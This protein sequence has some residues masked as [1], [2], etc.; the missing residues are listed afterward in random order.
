MQAF[1]KIHPAVTMVYFFAI[2]LLSMFV[3]NP[4]FNIISLL[5]AFLFSVITTGVQ[6]NLNDIKFYIPLLFLV[7]VTNPLFSHNGNTELLKILNFTI[8]YEALIYGVV[9]GIILITV[10]IWCKNY[11]LVMT[12]DKFVYLF[13]KAIPK[14]SLVITM[15]LRFVPMLRRQLHSINRT[16]K[17]LGLYSS[18]K[19]FDKIRNSCNVL[20]ILVGWSLENAVEIA[21]TMKSRGYGIK[22]H[23]NYSIYTFHKKDLVTLICMVFLI[24][25]TTV[26]I[27]MGYTSFEYY[28]HLSK[29]SFNTGEIIT[30]L[31]FTILAF[32]PTIIE[33]EESIRWSFYKSKI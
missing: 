17:A 24:A 6:K 1:T 5:G 23:T 29:L 4:V 8:T 14:L 19:Y 18:D 3:N 28:P 16:Q 9:F 13:G 2:L 12:S 26:G 30:Y 7:A 32:L 10:I 31:S 27:Y 15:A 20:L 25:V 21:R 22:G 11:N 33:V